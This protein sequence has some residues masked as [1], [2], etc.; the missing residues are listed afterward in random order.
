[1][2]FHEGRNGATRSLTSKLFWIVG[3]NGGNRDAAIMT[4]VTLGLAQGLS[5]PP[6]LKLLNDPVPDVMV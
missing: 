4:R 3:M 6:F 2:Q 1:M 5:S